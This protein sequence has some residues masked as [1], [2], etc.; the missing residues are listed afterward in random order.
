MNFK[1]KVSILG[2]LLVLFGACSSEML[3]DVDRTNKIV[4]NGIFAA[5]DTINLWLF[6]NASLYDTIQS[7]TDFRYDYGLENALVQL[8]EDAVLVGTLEQRNSYYAY[9]S[10][11]VARSGHHYTLSASCS[12]YPSITARCQ[13]PDATMIDTVSY[14]VSNDSINMKL[15]ITFSDPDVDE[16]YYAIRLYTKKNG[17]KKNRSFYNI[18]PV[19]GEELS[20]DFNL[21]RF[22]ADQKTVARADISDGGNQG[23]PISFHCILP[24]RFIDALSSNDIFPGDT[25][26]VLLY[27][28]PLSIYEYNQSVNAYEGIQQSGSE[29]ASIYTNVS[30]GIGIFSGY[31]YSY[32][33][34]NYQ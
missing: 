3:V 28:I 27:S 1:K 8:Y 12:N 29:P 32:Y 23:G 21:L 25:I 5:G 24:N 10:H 2:C 17:I 7:P 19:F 15:Q 11:V 9:Y 4:V 13:V 14:L 26:G 30:N 6:R 18:D 31:A 20:Y 16:N 34:F 33:E 22:S